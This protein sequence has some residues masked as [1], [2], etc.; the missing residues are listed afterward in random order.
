MILITVLAIAKILIISEMVLGVEPPREIG[1][2]SVTVSV[3]FPNTG[4]DAFSRDDDD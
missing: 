3:L 2:W 4:I 1:D